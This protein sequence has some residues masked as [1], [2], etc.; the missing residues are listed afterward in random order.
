[1][2]DLTDAQRHNPLNRVT[3]AMVAKQEA[4]LLAERALGENLHWLTDK[5]DLYIRQND[6]DTIARLQQLNEAWAELVKAI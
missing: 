3:N 4:I 5:L 6:S 1:M 2:N